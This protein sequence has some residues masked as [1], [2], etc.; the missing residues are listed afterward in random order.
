M[1]NLHVVNFDKMHFLKNDRTTNVLYCASD[2]VKQNNRLQME[3]K[4]S[5]MKDRTRLLVKRPT[6]EHLLKSKYMVKNI[7]ANH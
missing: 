7:E 6:V 4:M 3:R 5:L 1:V 2:S